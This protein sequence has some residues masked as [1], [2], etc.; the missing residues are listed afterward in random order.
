MLIFSIALAD[1]KT[2]AISYFDNTSGTKEYDPLSKGFADMLITDL[3]NVNSL[4][5]VER[6]K[7]ESL[8]IEIE[9]AG[10]DFLFVYALF[11]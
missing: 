8:L 10:I 6:E 3:S 4:K 1:T 7:L 2:L 5:I 11:I 9:L